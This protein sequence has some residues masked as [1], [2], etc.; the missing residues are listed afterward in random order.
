MLQ[1][2]HDLGRKSGFEFCFLYGHPTYY[3]RHGYRACFG[4]AK[5]TLDLDALP[6]PEQKFL[7]LPVCPSDVGWI[8]ERHAAELADVDFGWLW[9]PNLSEWVAAPMNSVVWWTEDGRRA[10]YTLCR[11]ARGGCELV[12]AEDPRLARDVIFTIFAKARERSRPK[13]P[14]I[15]QHP[16]G[17]LA[18]NALD[19]AW[20]HAEATRWDAAMAFELVPGVL[21]EYEDAL[22][23]GT[24]P[25]GVATFPIGFLAC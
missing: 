24:R 17:W 14:A 23:T 19:P 3:P 20:S 22:G 6:K 15:A 7:R 9:G 1:F 4:G 10:A 13:E 8:A 25:S 12:L 11:P 16:S 18:Q 2:G 21:K 5:I